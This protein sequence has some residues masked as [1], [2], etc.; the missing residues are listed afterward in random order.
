MARNDDVF[1]LEPNS[2]HRHC[3]HSV[4]IQNLII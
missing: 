3:E 2:Q 1:S 4:A